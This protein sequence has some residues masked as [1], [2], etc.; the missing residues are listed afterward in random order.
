MKIPKKWLVIGGIVLALV[1]AASIGGISVMADN[2]STTPTDTTTA[3]TTP[4]TTT[5]TAE[6][7][8]LNTV[9][10]IYQQ[11]TGQTIDEAALQTAI[12]QARTQIQTNAIQARLQELVSEGKLTQDQANQILS[13]WQ[14]MPDV[15]N[16]GG[17]GMIA[18]LGRGPGFMGRIGCIG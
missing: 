6:Q 14:S 16:G 2:S 8:F 11:N 10:S 9:V 17:L 18:G 15:L 7:N 3:T 13:W 5:T 12:E 1:L 4:P